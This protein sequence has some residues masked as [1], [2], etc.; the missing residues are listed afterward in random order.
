[1]P[2]QVDR[3]D[4]NQ[5]VESVRPFSTDIRI[6]MEIGV[7]L[8]CG[9]ALLFG[10]LAT[11]HA[12]RVAMVITLLTLAVATIWQVSKRKRLYAI[13]ADGILFI[14]IFSFIPIIPFFV[15]SLCIGA[16]SQLTRE[17][18]PLGPVSAILV[19]AFY[20]GFHLIVALGLGMIIR[21]VRRT[22]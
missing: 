12:G 13:L 18:L 1:M 14:G 22:E 19:T 15:G 4:S 11:N 17:T 5:S 10:T 2:S 9:W 6:S 21:A 16:V 7:A 3:D 20:F 8:S